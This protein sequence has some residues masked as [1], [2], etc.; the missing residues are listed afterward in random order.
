MP[1]LS[2]AQMLVYA[3][4]AVAVLLVAVRWLRSDA[5]PERGGV[6]DAHGAAGAGS[7]EVAPGA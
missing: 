6:V 7:F 2:R 1:E 3:A 4:I 5:D